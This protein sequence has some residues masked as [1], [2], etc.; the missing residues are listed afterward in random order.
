VLAQP[1]AAETNK[2]PGPDWQD[3]GREAT[4]VPNPET[5]KL[6]FLAWRAF[7]LL[8]LEMTLTSNVPTLACVCSAQVVASTFTHRGM[9][10]QEGNNYVVFSMITRMTDDLPQ[11]LD[12]GLADTPWHQREREWISAIQMYV[13]L[14]PMFST[15]NYGGRVPCRHHSVER[16]EIMKD[17]AFLQHEA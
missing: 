17:Q 14:L 12:Y 11:I 4:T 7:I 5:T 16:A 13:Y 1:H 2:S 9:A 15:V 3:Q 10:L 6:W 8:S